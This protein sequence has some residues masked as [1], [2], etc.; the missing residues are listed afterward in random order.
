MMV[1]LEDVAT[2]DRCGVAADAFQAVGLV[3]E[4]QKQ[5][6]NN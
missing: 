4:C 3:Q 2:A 6:G 1:W 5:V